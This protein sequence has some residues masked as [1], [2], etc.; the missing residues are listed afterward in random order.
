MGY[1]TDSLVI[2]KSVCG[3]SVYVYLFCLPCRFVY[4]HFLGIRVAGISFVMCG[5]ELLYPFT[6]A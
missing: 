1:K 5:H 2:S 3:F 6:L 4:F